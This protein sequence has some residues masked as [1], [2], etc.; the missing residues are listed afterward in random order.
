MD[1]WIY[2]NWMILVVIIL[3]FYNTMA[4]ECKSI[5][6]QKDREKTLRKITADYKETLNVKRYYSVNKI[7]FTFLNVSRRR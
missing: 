7:M 3:F 4:Q 6:H 2:K 5:F 1:G